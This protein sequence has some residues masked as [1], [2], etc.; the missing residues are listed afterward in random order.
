[1]VAVVQVVKLGGEA[2]VGGGAL[3]IEG[4]GAE[5]EEGGLVMGVKGERWWQM[6]WGEH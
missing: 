1:M 5:G 4:W 3:L 2:G 6:C